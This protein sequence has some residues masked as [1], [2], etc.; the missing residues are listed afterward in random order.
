MLVK[1]YKNKITYEITYPSQLFI[2]LMIK[3]NY[4]IQDMNGRQYELFI[5]SFDKN[6]FICNI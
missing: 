3:I 1:K 5:K 4:T 6:L 2:P